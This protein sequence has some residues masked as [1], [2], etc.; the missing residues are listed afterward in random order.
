M[1][2]AA[3]QG[4]QGDPGG[5]AAAAPRR[6]HPPAGEREGRRCG[7]DRRRHL[8][9][10][11]VSRP[12]LERRRPRPDADHPGSRRT[13]SSGCSGGTTFKLRRPLATRT[14]T[15]ATAPSYLRELLDRYDGNEVAALAAYNAGPG[16]ADNW[17]GS[18]MELDDIEFPETRAYVED[19]L[20]KQ[21]RIPQQV[22]ARSWAT[23]ER[24]LHDRVRGAGPRRRPGPRRLARS[25]FSPC[26]T[27][28]ASSDLASPG[29]PGCWSPSTSCW[30]SAAV[31]AA[32]LARRVGPGRAAAIG[33]A[34]F[35]GA[36]LACGVSDRPRLADR[37]SLPAGGRR[38][39]GRHRGPRADAV[40]RRAPSARRRSP[41]PRR[42]R[43]GQRSA[44]ASAAS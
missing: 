13:R 15:S 24:A 30:R 38:C 26:P 9:R 27:S 16:N 28:T 40:G 34:V 36:S 22:R 43:P 12:D 3:E 17:G 1:I 31:P 14:S 39:G 25:S 20:E 18:S 7:A 23:D 37:G 5:D 33:L 41:G 6:H 4:R 21:T 32:I 19:V 10:V 42:A 44:R 11:A 8:L 29:S 2:V 35:A